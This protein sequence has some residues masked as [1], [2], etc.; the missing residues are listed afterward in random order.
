[1]RTRCVLLFFLTSFMMS[2]SSS[3]TLDRDRAKK[4][5]EAS[6]EFAVQPAVVRISNDDIKRGEQ[7]GYWHVRQN[8][9]MWLEF[10]PEGARLFGGGVRGDVSMNLLALPYKLRRQ[11]VEITG[12]TDEPRLGQ[13][14]VAEFTWNWDF[15]GVPSEVKQF[16][17]KCAPRKY[18]AVFR[19]Y[20]DG[21]RLEEYGGEGGEKSQEWKYRGA[22]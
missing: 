6:K 13:A 14:K 2:C 20:D 12:I 3:K 17:Q 7:A 15:E 21:W 18:Y 10:T 4:L 19:L 5:M 11:L 22:S 1:M 8:V 16:F 9:N